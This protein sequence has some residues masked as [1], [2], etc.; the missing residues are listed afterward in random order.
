M[1]YGKNYY[2]SKKGILLKPTIVMFKYRKYNIIN[3]H[4]GYHIKK[5]YIIVNNKNDRLIKDIIISDCYHPN[6]WGGENGEIDIKKPPKFSKFCLPNDIKGSK[7]ISDSRMKKYSESI[8]IRPDYPFYSDI[9][10]R[11]MLMMWTLDD[12]HHF[13]LREHLKTTP[14]L[15]KEIL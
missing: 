3:C 12:P 1:I 2:E 13:P 10:I 8:T 5:Y 6:A 4:P 9:H 7:L 11:Y 14:T 15:P